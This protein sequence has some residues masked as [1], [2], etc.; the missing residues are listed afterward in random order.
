MVI[1]SKGN[2]GYEFIKQ[3]KHEIISIGRSEWQSLSEKDFYGV[4]IVLHAASDLKNSINEK[5]V[6]IIDSEVVVTVKLL[7][8]MRLASVPR[9]MYI[10]SCAVYGSG[11]T[12]EDS[13]CCPIS[14]N[15][16][17]KRLNESIIQSFCT[18]NNITWESYRVFNM[19]GGNDHFSVV[20]KIISSAKN[21]SN[22]NIYNSGASIRD[23]IH[24]NDVAKL[25]EFFVDN[26][27]GLKFLNLGTGCGTRIS[28]LV[29]LVQNKLPK[30]VVNNIQANLRDVASSVAYT[31]NFKKKLNHYKFISVR[32]Y[33]EDELSLLAEKL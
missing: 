31:N 25:I 9:L 14:I 3:S 4:D 10:S 21:K 5:P 20:S 7:E 17:I 11:E 23:F 29:T 12:N 33:L 1:G 16:Q 28:D 8:W 26:M 13:F 15:G 22:L 27:P 30:L 32:D 19:F 18:N 2:L 24:V 6:K